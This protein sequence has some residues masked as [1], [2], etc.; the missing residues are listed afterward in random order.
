MSIAQAFEG[1]IVQSILDIQT[2]GL[3]ILIAKL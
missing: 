2:R 3:M 1:N